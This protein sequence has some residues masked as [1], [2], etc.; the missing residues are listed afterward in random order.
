MRAVLFLINGFGIEAKESYSIYDASIMPNFDKL[1]TKY[2]FAKLNSSVF[3]T[4]DGFR[5]MSLEMN[6]LYNYGIYTRNIPSGKIAADPTVASINNILKNKQNKLHLLCFVDTS[7]QIVDNL[8]HFLSLINKEKD[9]KIFIHVVLTSN[10]YLDFPK[11]FEVLS[12]MNVA[13]E[14]MASIGMVMGLSNV[15]NSN[16][17][18]ELNFLLRNMITE[19]GEKWASFK[20]KLD[21]SYG[22]K[23]APSSVKPFVVNSGFALGS[24]DAFMIWNYDN[25]DITNFIDGVR[26]IDYGETPNTIT[27]SSLF[28]VTYKEN[29]P[30]VLDF[31]VANNSLASNM[32]GLGFKSMITCERDEIQAINYY[33]NGLQMVNNPDI[34]F[35]CLDD[36]KLDPATVVSVINSYPQELM[37]ISYNIQEVATVEELKTLLTKIDAVVGAIYDNTAKNSYNI[38]ISSLYG[39]KKVLPNASGELCNIVY[40]KV[41]IVYI[42]NFITKKDYLINDGDIKDLFK[43]CYK[44]MKKEY[45][46]ESLIVK[47]NILYRLIFK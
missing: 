46:G 29:I 7:M 30:H 16:P 3:N 42:D 12:K 27:F 23:S 28:P 41:P 25:I 17:I 8:K 15:L 33:V 43:V 9:K 24:S 14:G 34:S 38:I 1:S 4:I 10:N 19:M 11:I 18:V 39:M 47:K 31:E 40:S 5:S 2:M 21:F 35:I 36:R 20:Q 44:S 26:M 32:K 45:P 6:D 37:V 13:L 22:T